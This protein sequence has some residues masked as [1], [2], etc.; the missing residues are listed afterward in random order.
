MGLKERVQDDLKQSFKRR[1]EAAVRTLKMLSAEIHNAEIAKRPDEL[2][3]ED[4]QAV[5]KR[6]AKKRRQA[7]ELYEKAHRAELAEKEAQELAVLKRYL[8]EAQ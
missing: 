5:V 8:A 1:E 4:V 2:T 3:E 6:A 7:I